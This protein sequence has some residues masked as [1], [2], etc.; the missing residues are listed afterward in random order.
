MCMDSYTTF[1]HCFSPNV[2]NIK[3]WRWWPS[4]IAKPIHVG[5]LVSRDETMYLW[6]ETWQSSRRLSWKPGRLIDFL[7]KYC[8]KQDERLRVSPGQR[9]IKKSILV[10]LLMVGSAIHYQKSMGEVD[11]PCQQ[12]LPII[13]TPKHGKSTHA[14][15]SA[16][17]IYIY[18]TIIR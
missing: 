1:V 4:W 5:F 12:G 10:M 7:C 6:F 14:G 11:P 2:K 9:I 3:F 18:L 13:N 16:I 15:F 17:Y 8:R